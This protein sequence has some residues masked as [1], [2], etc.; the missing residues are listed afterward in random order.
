MKLEKREITLNE[1][2]SLTDAFYT[3]KNLK[4][5]YLYAMENAQRKECK[6][7]LKSLLKEV[8]NDLRSI[9]DLMEKSMEAQRKFNGGA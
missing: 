2:D 7:T 1:T 3:L 9:G 5:H 4:T 8:E 6:E